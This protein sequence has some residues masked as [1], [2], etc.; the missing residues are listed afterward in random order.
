MAITRLTDLS[1]S[2]M[3]FS[4]VG[5]A[6]NSFS[7]V[8]TLKSFLAELENWAGDMIAHSFQNADECLKVSTVFRLLSMGV[9]RLGLFA[10]SLSLIPL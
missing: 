10:Q 4:R 1:N 3:A 2:S 7:K 8:L 5:N 9:W 6:E